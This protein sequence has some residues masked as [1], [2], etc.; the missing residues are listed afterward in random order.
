MSETTVAQLVNQHD[1]WLQERRDLRHVGR[2][3]LGHRAEMVDL[4]QKAA[5]IRTV[6]REERGLPALA[7]CLAWQS[8]LLDVG[9]GVPSSSTRPARRMVFVREYLDAQVQAYREIPATAFAD[10]WLPYVDGLVADRLAVFRVRHAVQTR[11]DTVVDERMWNVLGAWSRDAL[12]YAQPDD[13]MIAATARLITEGLLDWPKVAEHRSEEMRDPEGAEPV[14]VAGQEVVLTALGRR[15]VDRH[16]E[17]I[18]ALE[19]PR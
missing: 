11:T 18:T 14:R 9:E 10:T 4:K 2:H 16:R 12:T 13:Q 15:L 1:L 6:L 19:D 7:E 5:R 3:D 17:R 8:I